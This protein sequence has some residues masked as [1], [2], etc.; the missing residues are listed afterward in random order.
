VKG[1]VVRVWGYG[2]YRIEAVQTKGDDRQPNV[3][4]IKTVTIPRVI[5]KTK[6]KK[7]ETGSKDDGHTSRNQLPKGFYGSTVR[8]ASLLTEH[9]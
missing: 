6:T 3:F 7:K 2:Q 1:F 8:Y 5:P 4:Q 9:R